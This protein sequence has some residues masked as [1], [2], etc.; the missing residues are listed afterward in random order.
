MTYNFTDDSALMKEYHNALKEK[1]ARE[2]KTLGDRL[3]YFTLNEGES[4]EVRVVQLSGQATFVKQAVCF[5]AKVNCPGITIPPKIKYVTYA[6]H[7]DCI[8][9]K[10]MSRINEEKLKYDFES[11]ENKKYF[12]MKGTVEP[13]PVLYMVV[14]DR[15]DGLLKIWNTNKATGEEVLEIA[16]DP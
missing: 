14:I 12:M 7:P 1:P 5:V 6:D 2:N 10:I 11:A 4:A 13:T 3:P 16:T 9:H 8:S 15:R